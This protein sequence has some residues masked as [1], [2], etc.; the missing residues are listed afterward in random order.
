MTSP[1]ARLLRVIA[2][3]GL[4]YQSYVHFD[5]AAT[6]DAIRTSTLSQG[7]LFRVEG[8]AAA[9]A[10]LAVLVLH[11][12]WSAA[13]AAS[14]AGGGLAAVLL[15]RFV[16]VG[17][18]GPLPNMTEMHWYPEKSRSAVAEALA[19]LAALGLVLV[20]RRVRTRRG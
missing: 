13:F 11:R 18:I 20:V 4:A 16:D 2:A 10:A 19:A 8:V 9:I 12:W 5:L 17:R 15:Y 1:A 6:Y 14:V 7:D 3:L